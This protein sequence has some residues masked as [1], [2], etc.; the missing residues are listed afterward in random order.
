MEV[1][2][3]SIDALIGKEQREKQAEE[4]ARRHATQLAFAVANRLR[5]LNMSSVELALRMGVKPSYVSRILAG[6][7]NVTLKTIAKIEVALDFSFA[8]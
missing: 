4:L 2:D 3:I 5:E 8:G 1:E 6:K 7:Q